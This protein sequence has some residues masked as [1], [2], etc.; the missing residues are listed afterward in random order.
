MYMFN[1]VG[2]GDEGDRMCRRDFE[3]TY[4]S[5]RDG[6]RRE[7]EQYMSNGVADDFEA[8][9]TFL[10]RSPCENVSEDYWLVDI[11]ELHANSTARLRLLLSCGLGLGRLLSVAANHDQ[12]QEGSNHGRCQ[13]NENNGDA[14]SPDAGEEEVLEDMI[15]V[16]KG[17][18]RVSGVLLGT[19][20]L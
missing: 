14:D 10:R 5:R 2:R 8:S 7:A 6:E 15:V 16:D 9:L 1:F 3:P 19:G 20:S 11:G 13:K 17:L 12:A 4:T 18:G